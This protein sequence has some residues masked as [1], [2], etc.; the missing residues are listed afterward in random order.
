VQSKRQEETQLVYLQKNSNMYDGVYEAMV[1]AGV[2]IKH[3]EEKLFDADG[4][5]VPD[6]QQMA[7]RPS[8]YE[9]KRSQCLFFVDETGCNTNQKDDGYVGGELFVLPAK[10]LEFGIVGSAVDIH[11][12]V[13]SFNNALGVPLMFTDIL[14][15]D[16]HI[17]EIPT[18]WKLGIDIRKDIETGRNNYETFEANYSD[19]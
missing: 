13:L 5:I 7:G 3:D 17:S 9:L 18:S 16:R 8:K 2:A 19:G 15:S 6:V 4:N 10:Y 12:S 14:Q 11:F 1:G